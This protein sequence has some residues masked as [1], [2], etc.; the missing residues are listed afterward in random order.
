MQESLYSAEISLKRVVVV[1][2]AHTSIVPIQTLQAGY[3]ERDV[4]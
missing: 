3:L 2:L 4:T 1:M